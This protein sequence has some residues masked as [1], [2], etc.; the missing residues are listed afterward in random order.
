MIGPTK[1]ST[2]KSRTTGMR[3]V[4][5]HAQHLIDASGESSETPA[6]ETVDV[7][8]KSIP[9]SRLLG[10]PSFPSEGRPLRVDST[11]ETTAAAADDV[12]TQR[13]IDSSSEM[14]V[15][16]A[17]AGDVMV[18][19]LLTVARVPFPTIRHHIK[20]TSHS[21][22][23]IVSAAFNSESKLLVLSTS[24]EVGLFGTRALIERFDRRTGSGT[25][26]CTHRCVITEV[27]HKSIPK[28]RLLGSPSFQS[29]G[30]PL[31]V[32]STNKTRVDKWRNSTQRSGLRR[33]EIKVVVMPV[34]VFVSEE[35]KEMA[36]NL[37]TRLHDLLAEL[38]SKYESN[39]EAPKAEAFLATLRGTN[40]G[41][42]V[43]SEPTRLSWFAAEVLP[44]SQ[45]ERESLLMEDSV[46][47]RLEAATT[48]IEHL[49]KEDAMLALEQDAEVAQGVRQPIPESIPKSMGIPMSKSRLLGSPS[50]PSEGRLRIGK[51]PP[52]VVHT[53]SKVQ[54]LTD[55]EVADMFLLKT[56]QCEND[57][58]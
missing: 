31:R 4:T 18:L 46:T 29:E 51:D 52:L 6:A 44:F 17:L 19:P 15:T 45:G 9:K 32:N 39:L 11:N 47:A 49:L 54:H 42:K 33:G 14:P 21:D 40:P 13:L 41:W 34:D 2:A 58:N 26:I 53:K 10:S 55:S 48:L 3:R 56:H 12:H 7:V 1:G 35:E 24:S 5:I 38:R 8:N 27:P 25:V 28:S 20:C 22:I 43:P 23:E 50:F 37:A 30:R 57:D 36:Q 16:A